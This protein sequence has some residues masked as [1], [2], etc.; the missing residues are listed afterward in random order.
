MKW[1]IASR[2][3]DA[4]LVENISKTLE[5]KNQQI[6]YKWIEQKSLKPYGDNSVECKK[7]AYEISSSIQDSNVFVLISDEQGTDMFVELGIAISSFEHS[8]LPRIYIIGEHNK[9]SLMHFHSSIKHCDSI[10]Q[11]LELEK[12]K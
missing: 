3:K 11:V 8:S 10:N 4:H 2:K 9:R 1:Y 7:I 5:L 12:V 6:S